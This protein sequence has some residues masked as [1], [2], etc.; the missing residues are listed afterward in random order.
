MPHLANPRNRRLRSLSELKALPVGTRI[1][2]VFDSLDEECGEQ[3]GIK[4]NPS[5]GRQSIRWD[6]E[7]GGGGWLPNEVAFDSAIVEVVAIDSVRWCQTCRVAVV[8]DGDRCLGPN[9]PK[10]SQ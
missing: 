3:T 8:H 2:V 6:D 10:E 1:R 5:R 7:I 9:H 4:D